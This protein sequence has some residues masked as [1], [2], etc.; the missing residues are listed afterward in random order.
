MNKEQDKKDM[1]MLESRQFI[2]PKSVAEFLMHGNFPDG[3][4]K[5][6]EVVVL[7]CC[8]V[9]H[10]SKQITVSDDE[11]LTEALDNAERNG[12]PRGA[13]IYTLA[14]EDGMKL[15]RDKLTKKSK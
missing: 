2:T 4:E 1:D 9:Y 15:M 14:F 13:G 8:E 6:I 7:K 10:Q 12:F 11:I 3:Y 5:N